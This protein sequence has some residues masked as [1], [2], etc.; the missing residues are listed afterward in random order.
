MAFDPVGK[1]LPL[2]SLLPLRKLP[3][4]IRDTE[5]YKCIASS[6]R[7]VGLIEPLVVYPQSDGVHYTVLDGTV[8]LDILKNQGTTDVF[9]LI[10]NDDEGYT[11]NHKVNQLS[12][13]Q[14]HFMIMKAIEHG[15]PEERIAVTL[16]VNV[17]AIRRKKNLLEGICPEAVLLLKDKK[18]PVA[19]LREI[20]RVVPMRQIEMA[21]LMIGANN[22]GV[23]YAKS[24]YVGTSP[25]KRL[26]GETKTN[27]GISSADQLRMEREMTML[28]RN[29]NAMQDT[30]G[31]SVLCLQLAS[32]YLKK[33]LDNGRIVRYLSQ[34]H[35][36]IL[37]E[38]QKIIET[39]DLG[40]NQRTVE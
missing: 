10:S 9:C 12:A 17:H 18:V 38:L 8:R 30:Y 15:V 19:A 4:G 27:T 26:P 31:E 39:P 13:I 14:E 33:L 34:R 28:H 35:A 2:A 1:I 29:F 24:L 11:Y 25:V 22:Y 37:A 20:K 32:G 5:K 7:E 36:D 40:G 3:T 16:N 6:I 21:E 23:S